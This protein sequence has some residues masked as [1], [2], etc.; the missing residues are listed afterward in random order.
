V[1][2]PEG[3]HLAQLNIGTAVDDMDSPR[4]AEFMR[5][6]DHVNGIAEKSK[7]F[8]WMLKDEGGEGATGIQT[9][10]NPRDLVNLTV[11]ETTD[12]LS[13]FVWETVHKKFYDKRGRWFLDLDIPTFCMWWIPAGHTPTVQEALDRLDDLRIN[14]PSDRAFGWSEL[15][16]T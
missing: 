6:L 2:Q 15:Q 10:P 9:T 3:T 8:V 16:A 7:G 1:V 11:W 14:G 5:S 4:L 13:K 12:D